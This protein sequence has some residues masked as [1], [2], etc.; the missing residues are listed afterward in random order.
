VAIVA[1]DGVVLGDLSVPCELFGRALDGQGRHLY[2]V[3]VCSLMP[4]VQSEHVVL[5]VRWRLSSL[6][7]ADTIVVPGLDDLNRPMP[8]ALLNALRAAI[9]RGTR[10][11][12]IC[13]GAFIL[14]ATGALDGLRATTHWAAAAELARRNPG[15]QVD[16]DVLYVDNGKLLT[17]AGAAA[18]VDLCLHLVRCDHGAQVAAEVARAAVVPLERAGGQS[19]FIVHAP[20]TIDCGTLSPL[21]PCLAQNL[22]RT[23]SLAVVAR[24]ASMSTRT[25][26]RRFREQTGRKWRPKWDSARRRCYASI[27]AGRLEPARKRIAAPFALAELSRGKRGRW[28]PRHPIRREWF[29]HAP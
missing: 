15:I 24:R 14:A 16:P 18:G 26:S 1:F 19:Q 2:E 6:R 22:R 28:S 25:L 10:V 5:R 23:L 20:P 17:S 4:E 7:D 8:P 29:H 12:S 9:A 3:R 21:L 11:A 27:S 13:S